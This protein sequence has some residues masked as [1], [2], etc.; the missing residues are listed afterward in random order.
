VGAVAA[1]LHRSFDELGLAYEDAFAL[2]VAV[3]EAVENVV[4]HGVTDGT[5]HRVEVSI[6][7]SAEAVEIVIADD[8][9]PFDPLSVSPPERPAQLADVVPGGQGVHL[10][11]H[12][13][14]ALSYRHE[15]GHN[16]L[17]LTRRIARPDRGD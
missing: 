8:A 13:T 16:V 10:I 17:V 15:G 11:R 12:F 6:R 14:D 7:A 1:W 9:A 5:T 4:R 3:H 2:D